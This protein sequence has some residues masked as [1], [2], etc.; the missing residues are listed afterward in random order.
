M[1]EILYEK[2]LGNSVFKVIFG[3]I[4]EATT[5]AIVNPA[6]SNLILGG[7]VAGAIRTAGGAEIQ[8]ECN[9]IGHC[10]VGDAKI[11]RAG[12]L[13]AKWVIHAVGPVY[14][15]YEAKEAER[16][17]RSAIRAVFRIVSEKGLLSVTFP[18]IS[19]GI[20]GYPLD[21]AFKIHVEELEEFATLS[22]EKRIIQLI[23]YPKPNADYFNQK[24]KPKL[25]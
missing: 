2:S 3:N 20:F 10:D 25:S 23:L 4:V 15:E 22:P 16:L 6:N 19:A 11:T 8:I 1:A 7:G 18:L 5:D 13:K 9:K 24:I 14:S 17:L 12:S 21:E